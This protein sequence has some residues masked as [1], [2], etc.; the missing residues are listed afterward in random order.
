MTFD[1]IKLDDEDD[2]REREDDLTGIESQ[3]SFKVTSSL[4]SQSQVGSNTL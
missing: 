2:I 1:P 4:K 3:F